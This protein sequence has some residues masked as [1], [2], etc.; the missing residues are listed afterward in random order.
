MLQ[1]IFAQR[2]HLHLR[3]VLGGNDHSV[4][5]HGPVALVF[6]SHLALAVR[7]QIVQRAVLA[8]V[9]QPLCQLVRQRNGQRHQLRRLAAGVAEHHALV[10]RAARGH[11]HGDIGALLVDIG[12]HGA[13]VRVKAVFGAGI[14]DVPHNVAHNL[15][16]I[17]IAFRGDLTHDMHK[18]RTGSHL[19]GHTAV[20]VFFQQRVQNGVGDLVADLI[21]MPL[22]DG[23]GGKKFSCH[24]CFPF[25]FPAKARK[26]GPADNTGPLHQLIFRCY[27][28][29][30]APCCYSR[31]P[32]V[33]GPVPSV[34]LDKVYSFVYNSIAE[35]HA[36]VKRRPVLFRRTPD[37]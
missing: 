15:L 1:N 12:K 37:G 31:L 9:R 20:R 29:D 13:C 27:P 11:A 35:H 6:H 5:T 16:E 21:G 2:L 25:L 3:S 23:F 19:T 32:D 30:L 7:A 24:F 36:P 17:H 33:T 10:A 28:Q 18:A 8:H 14:T 34:A 22:G 26:K 4:H